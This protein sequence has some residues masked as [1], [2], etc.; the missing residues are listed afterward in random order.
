MAKTMSFSKNQG[1]YSKVTKKPKPEKQELRKDIGK[2]KPEKQ[3]LRKDIGKIKPEKQELRKDIGKIKPEKQE[4]RKMTKKS[5]AKIVL[6]KEIL[7]PETYTF[8]KKHTKTPA[9]LEA[10]KHIKYFLKSVLGEEC[11]DFLYKLKLDFVYE[12]SCL[13]VDYERRIACK[14]LYILQSKGIAE[15]IKKERVEEKARFDFLWAVKS[16]EILRQTHL[17]YVNKLNKI[18]VI[19]DIIST[20]EAYVDSA[21][22]IYS[23]DEA[24]EC[25]FVGEDGAELKHCNLQKLL[26]EKHT[27]ERIITSLTDV[28]ITSL[29]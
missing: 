25:N 15:Y 22:K 19:L 13:K 10:L 26:K 14:Y 18:N 2:I 6:K 27:L 11:A 20:Q 7:Q 23:F 5:T 29:V 16:E 17:F 1:K 9:S 28:Q 24:V 4:L 8:P 12:D 21:E 3:E